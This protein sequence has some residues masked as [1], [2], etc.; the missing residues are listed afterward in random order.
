M[1][2]NSL[3]PLTRSPC[4]A[5]L[6]QRR[7]FNAALAC[8][9]NSN[10][11]S[12]SES[13]IEREALLD[14]RKTLTSASS[15]NILA[16]L[17]YARLLRRSTGARESRYV[18]AGSLV[19]SLA[20]L[21]ALGAPC[22]PHFQWSAAAGGAAAPL[23]GQPTIIGNARTNKRPPQWNLARKSPNSIRFIQIQFQS[24]IESC[25]F[26]K[27]YCVTSMQWAHNE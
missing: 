5:V 7:S 18:R 23:R 11:S 1:E 20:R 2:T 3:V 9:A 12:K 25:R 14:G 16:L 6:L 4:F 26:V 15:Y 8:C 21:Q 19:R 22:R 17:Q 10:C 27:R 24:S 13:S